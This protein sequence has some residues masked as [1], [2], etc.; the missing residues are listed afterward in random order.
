[1]PVKFSSKWQTSNFSLCPYLT[2]RARDLH[3]LY[4]LKAL[5][6]YIQPHWA[7]YF[8][9]LIAIQRGLKFK[10]ELG[11]STSFKSITISQ[12][13]CTQIL[14]L[15]S[16]PGDELRYCFPMPGLCLCSLPFYLN[17]HHIPR[18]I[19]TLTFEIRIMKFKRL[20]NWYV[21]VERAE[22]PEIRNGSAENCCLEG[23]HR[24]CL[25]NVWIWTCK[26]Q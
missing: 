23:L 13:T 6:P 22:G 17:S 14:V 11:G 8:C 26:T 21:M 24:Q 20:C 9:L 3:G 15:G 25:L 4:F 2:K 18:N 10:H 16:A 5:N 19:L 12:T 1:M 7:S